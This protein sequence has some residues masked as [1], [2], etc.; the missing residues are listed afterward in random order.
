MPLNVD[1]LNKQ[2]KKLLIALSH[3]YKPTSGDVISD[4]DMVLV[5]YPKE[6]IVEAASY[7]DCFG[8]R[9]VNS[10]DKFMISP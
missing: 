8:F 2:P 10:D 4:P 9:S 5:V 7:Q 3:Y 1:I 6:K